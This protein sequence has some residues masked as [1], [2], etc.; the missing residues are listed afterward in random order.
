MGGCLAGGC[1]PRGICPGGGF[2]PRG[3][4]A[5]GGLTGGGVFI[6]CVFTLTYRNKINFVIAGW[7]LGLIYY[8][9]IGWKSRIWNVKLAFKV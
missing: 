6:V 8:T 3:V 5:G 9:V 4:S 7:L 1:L 2:L